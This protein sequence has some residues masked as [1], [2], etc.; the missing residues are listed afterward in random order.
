MKFIQHDDEL[1]LVPQHISKYGVYSGHII[2]VPILYSFYDNY[3][4]LGCILFLLYITTI[5]SWYKIYHKSTIKN[6]DIC[7]VLCTLLK[8]SF[9]DSLR[10]GVNR[11]VWF[12]SMYT[13]ISIFIIN[14]FIF[15]NKI[16]NKESILYCPV[17]TMSRENAY[18][19]NVFI[20]I[21]FIH[22]VLNFIGGYCAIMVYYTNPQDIKNEHGNNIIF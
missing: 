5:L 11:N 14:Q 7:L 13:I 15:Y 22:F 9:H 3:T 19:V 8:V 10:W 21:F 17:N 6:I 1:V 12:Y 4:S 20:H 18:Y 16:Y 2:W